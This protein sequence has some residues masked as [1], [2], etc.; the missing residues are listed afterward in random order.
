M[1]IRFC[2]SR[3]L[4]GHI[5]RDIVHRRLADGNVANRDVVDRGSLRVLIDTHVA[6]IYLP[7]YLGVI[8]HQD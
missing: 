6:Q 4:D 1:Q 8:E 2:A 3:L 7:Q 5:H